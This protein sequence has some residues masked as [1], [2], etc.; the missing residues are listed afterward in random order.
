MAF[1]VRPFKELIAMTKEKLDEALIPLRVRAA[2][3]KADTEL[4][5]YEEKLVTLEAQ[6]NEE[7]AKKELDFDK[8]T[9][10][11]DDYDIAERRRGQIE[12]LV[13]KL[14]AEDK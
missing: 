9:T 1:Q 11:L 10:L 7:C 3:A 14:F 4:I 2:K 8:I 5:K 6:I 13:S 12:D